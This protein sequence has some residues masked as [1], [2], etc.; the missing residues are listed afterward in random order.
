[1]KDDFNKIDE[2]LRSTLEGYRKSPSPGLWRNI[3]G[4]LFFRRMLGFLNS[5]PWLMAT[6]VFI[7]MILLYIAI[8]KDDTL[9]VTSLPPVARVSHETNPLPGEPE[10]ITPPSDPAPAINTSAVTAHEANDPTIVQDKKALPASTPVSMTKGPDVK[11]T[12]VTSSPVLLSDTAA[13][14]QKASAEESLPALRQ[15]ASLPPAAGLTPPPGM[16]ALKSSMLGLPTAYP[17]IRE[18]LIHPYSPGSGSPPDHYYR[19]SPSILEINLGY[20][21]VYY[22]SRMVSPRRAYG[23]GLLYLKDLDPFTIGLGAGFTI[24][25]DNGDYLIRY[26]Q[27]DSIGYYY[28]VKSF[29]IDPE[30]QQPVFNTS[31]TG[32]YDSVEYSTGQNPGNKYYYLQLPFVLGYKVW[33][34]RRL[35][36]SLRGGPLLSILVKADESPASYSN[37]RA[38]WVVISDKTPKRIKSNWQLGLEGVLSYAL[39]KNLSVNLEPFCRYYLKSPYEN[40]RV[41]DKTTWSLGGRVGISIDF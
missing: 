2:L 10:Q 9:P 14:G 15:T 34:T 31:I 6:L 39:R 33:E 8:Q 30:T 20:E 26:A 17:F 11:R 16:L 25:E 13:S 12:I 38:V 5:I 29:V 24:S 21:G 27:Y 19:K 23:A 37:S 7:T 28:D 4:A 1:M 18:S 35:S 36:F 32:V 41:K 22:H 40:L 3:S